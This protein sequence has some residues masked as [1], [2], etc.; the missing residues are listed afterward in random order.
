MASNKEKLKCPNVSEFIEEVQNGIT[1]ME[2]SKKYKVS[3]SLISR[4]RV[5]L[6]V[7]K[8]FLFKEL[9]KKQFTL[10]CSTLLVKELM[11]KY[12]VSDATIRLWKRKLGISVQQPLQK[13][14]DEFL[15]EVREKHGDNFEILEQYTNSYTKIKILHKKCGLIFE[16]TP[17]GFLSYI[18][19]PECSI[20]QRDKRNLKK[21]SNR[22]KKYVEQNLTGEYIA[23]SEY[24]GTQEPIRMKHLTCGNVYFTTPSSIM[25]G[26]GCP[27]CGHERT[28]A[29]TRKTH[30]EFLEEF[31]KIYGNE[32][33]VVSEYK[34]SYTSVTILHKKCGETYKKVPKTLLDTGSLCPYCKTKSISNGEKRIEQ[35]LISNN[36][37]YEMQYSFPDCADERLLKFDFAVFDSANKLI[38]L[39]EF[40]GLQH[41]KPIKY[42]GGIE[43]YKS[44]IRRDSIKNDYCKNQNIELIRIPYNRFRD[45]ETILNEKLRP[46]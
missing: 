6:G 29:S 11:E 23:L 24:L 27:E 40:D 46:N 1:V 5:E 35:Y 43:T 21:Y 10:D 41:F 22:F 4:W 34:N 14:H 2:Q 33:E 44:V 19:C 36:L 39:I 7:G 3:H 32:Y 28:V 30:G 37:K 26:H 31:H 9:D 16:A 18:G 8:Q 17:S 42:Y 38:L 15:Q 20:K 13:T 25:L 45:I 12:D